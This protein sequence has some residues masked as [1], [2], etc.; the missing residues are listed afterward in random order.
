MSGKVSAAGDAIITTEP[1]HR[2][3]TDAGFSGNQPSSLGFASKP[4]LCRTVTVGSSLLDF[5]NREALHEG[6]WGL[7]HQIGRQASVKGDSLGLL[8]IYQSEALKG[9]FKSGL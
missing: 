1:C 6:A 7:C 4:L 9:A 2:V 5:H 8:K 3:F